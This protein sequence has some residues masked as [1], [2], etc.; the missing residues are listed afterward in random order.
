MISATNRNPLEAVQAG[1]LR[2]DLYFRINTIEIHI[3]PLRE[4]LDD[5]PLLAEHFLQ[6]YAEKY[7]RD[8]K[9]FSQQAYNQLLNHPWRGNIRELQHAIERAVLLCKTKKIEVLGIA[10]E[11]SSTF[12]AVSNSTIGETPTPIQPQFITKNKKAEPENST[13]SDQIE[14]LTNLNEKQFYEEIGKL[15]VNKIPKGNDENEDVFTKIEYG[16]VVAALE[17]SKQNKKAA[18]TLLGVYRPRL[19]GMLKRHNLE[20]E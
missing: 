19:Y 7:R 16:I 18:A 13:I 4:R 8:V 5:V 14:N 11:N 20:N 6:E 2:E 10:G 12:V 1:I 3:P 17:K 9:E 15:I